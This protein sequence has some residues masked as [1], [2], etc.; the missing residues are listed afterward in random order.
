MPPLSECMQRVTGTSDAVILVQRT[1]GT[2][3]ASAP[4]ADYSR[5]AGPNGP[6]LASDSAASGS[7]AEG[8]AVG[9]ALSEGAVW[10]FALSEPLIDSAGLGAGLGGVASDS[11]QRVVTRDTPGAPTL[12]DAAQLAGGTNAARATFCA[13]AANGGVW[14]W[15][16]ALGGVL[17]QGNQDRAS[18]A[19]PVLVDPNTALGLALEVRVGD[20]SACARTSDGSV[21]CWGSNASGELGR[22]VTGDSDA[23]A[24]AV[25]VVLPLPATRLSASPGLTHCAV[26][27]DSSVACWGRND[28]AQAGAPSAQGAL[29]PA[30]VRR[31]DGGPVFDHVL[32]LAPDRGARAM[33][34]NTEADGLWCWGDVP[35]GQDAGDAAAGSPYPQLALKTPQGRIH[36][37]LSAYGAQNGKLI[38]VNPNGRLVLGAKSAPTTR[39]PPCP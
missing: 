20:A 24:Y 3:W 32:D 9:C 11:A 6:L 13:V 17:A 4:S 28:F 22:A 1:D 12:D 21:W 2:L 36:V 30:V 16:Q 19:K 5:V 29:P 39:Q 18:Y 14:C 10:C 33:C 37:P 8:S 15:G 26:L 23:S 35:G 27:A 31:S 34:A 25:R 38:Y 7:S